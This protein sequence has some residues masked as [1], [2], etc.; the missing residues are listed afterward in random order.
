MI[1]VVSDIHGKY[2]KYMELLEKI[3]LSA[4]DTL[5]VLG[6]VVDRGEKPIEIL[7][8]MMKRPNVFPLIGNHDYVAA[9]VLKRLSCEIT[10]ESISALDNDTLDILY[11]WLKD[12][13]ET[14]LDGFLKLSPIERQK[15]LDYLGE[16]ELY[17]EVAAGGNEYLLVHGGLGNYSHE[18]GLC[19]YN[20]DEL[21]TF[22]TDYSKPLFSGNKYLVTGHTPTQK[23][24]ENLNPG[25]IYRANNH[26]A[27]DCGAVFGGSL[28]AICLDTGEEFYV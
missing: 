1:Y 2:D 23:I 4:D 15:V 18:K 28:A 9:L 20:L 13:G 16:F 11:D 5:Y 10:E 17:A 6:D 26:I 25:K 19:E 8:D 3:K 12:G 27:I 7:H 14:T 21:L 22:R 24:P